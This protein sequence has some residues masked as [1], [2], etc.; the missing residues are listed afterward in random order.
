MKFSALRMAGFRGMR[1]PMEISFPLGFTV[2][3]GRNG[4]GKSS[5]CDTL[6]QNSS[7]CLAPAP[8]A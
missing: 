1:E 4:T 5:I 3:S 7:E 8:A 2:I 6:V